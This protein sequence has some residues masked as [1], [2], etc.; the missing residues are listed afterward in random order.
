MFTLTQI[1]EVTRQSSCSQE[2]D[3][4]WIIFIMALSCHKINMWY[5]DPGYQIVRANEKLSLLQARM[6]GRPNTFSNNFKHCNYTNLKE[7]MVGSKF[8]DKKDINW[9]LIINR[10]SPA[11][12]HSWIRCII[13]HEWYM[14][15]ARSKEDISID[16]KFLLKMAQ[17]KEKI[18]CLLSYIIYIQ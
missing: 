3:S 16:T 17:V 15:P 5:P 7:V 10:W 18:Y 4:N 6:T 9:L 12:N 2:P 11:I 1:T 8:V 14:F 13:D